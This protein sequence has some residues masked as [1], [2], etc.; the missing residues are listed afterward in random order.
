MSPVGMLQWVNKMSL[1]NAEAEQ[2]ATKEAAKTVSSVWDV[3]ANEINT[4][5]PNLQF[6]PRVSEAG[7]TRWRDVK[8][9]SMGKGRD[10][11]E[12][13][14]LLHFVPMIFSNFFIYTANML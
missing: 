13:H 2:D 4:A 7:G 5:I 14:S 3:R 12:S 9:C 10:L 1:W 8:L 11:E 6:D